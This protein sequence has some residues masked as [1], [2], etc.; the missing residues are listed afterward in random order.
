MLLQNS[1]KLGISALSTNMTSRGPI[2]LTS[3]SEMPITQ[4][5]FHVLWLTH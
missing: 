1:L 3:P 4:D 2:L 5:P